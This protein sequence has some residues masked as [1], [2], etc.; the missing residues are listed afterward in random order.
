M[1]ALLLKEIRSFLSSLIGYIVISVFLLLIGLFTWVFSTPFNI[2]ES[3]FAD[4]DPLFSLAPLVFLFL[5][6]AITMRTFAEEKRTGTIEL[7]LTRP[8]TD[9]QIVLSKYLAGLLLVLFSL[10]PTLVYYF[11]ISRLGDPPGNVDT[12]GMWGS[13]L[14]LLL[15]GAGFVAIGMF[16]SALT[17][18]QIVAFII[19]V[20]LC[21]FFYLG[22]DFLGSYSL[23]G[24]YD[25][26]VKNL[27]IF[28]HYT[29]LSRGVVDSRDVIYFLSLIVFF[30]LLTRVVLE[31]RKRIHAALF[32][33]S[34]LIMVAVNII[35][36]FRFVRFDLTE[37]KRHSLSASTIHFLEDK[38]EDV[39][40]FK[41]YLTGNLPAELKRVEREIR[42][43]LEEMVAYAGDRIQYEFFDPY[44][45]E[46]EKARMTLMDELDYEKK[47]KYSQ[48]ESMDKGKLSVNFLF[49]GATL[50]FREKEI[51]FNFFVKP[52]IAREENV[53][54]LADA[55]INNIEYQLMDAMRKAIR[56]QKPRIAILEGHGEADADRLGIVTNALREFYNVERVAIDNQIHA[57]LEFD[58]VLIVKPQTAFSEKDKFVIDQF[59][60]K[61]GKAAWFIDPLEVREDT[62][63]KR[64]QT[65]G[66]SRNLNLDDQLF[67]YGIA[68]NKNLIVDK[69][70]APIAIPGYANQFHEWYFFPLITPER[71][72]PITRSIDPIKTQYASSLRMVGEDAGMKKTV[73]LKSSPTSFFYNAPVR[74][75][76]GVI[77]MG[78]N[79]WQNLK[80]EQP[81]AILLEGEFN[82]VF[83]NRLAPEFTS[84]PDY[85]Y[86]ERSRANR[87]L[88]VG[89]GDLILNEVDS[90]EM[91]GRM[92]K[93]YLKLSHDKYRITNP[94]GSPRFI[95]G[96]R[97]FL[98][99]A[100]DYLLGDNELIE[101]RQRTITIRRLDQE[102][103][104]AE[105]GMWQFVN[106]ALPVLL[107]ICF[108]F[109]QHLVRKR[110]YTL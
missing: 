61:G 43:K 57:L 27:G 102:K 17:H 106:V 97:E 108:G 7:L 9:M 14:G 1:L 86:V 74:I 6:P 76:Y 65:F 101:I 94:D 39:A 87:M 81:I 70:A 48:I 12:G 92:E 16:S 95:Y 54:R 44:S 109:I 69:I 93:R 41:I 13:Y 62:L 68:L 38:L 4:L 55:A 15:L 104:M 10:L 45:I 50:S 24:G 31:S 22:F 66:L 107:L 71:S 34:V 63:F 83:K 8:L 51:S 40:Y 28:S 75:N 52:Y 59:I 82:S 19:S 23:F 73:L 96:N 79:L 18:N 5:V 88:V 110:R 11:S 72:H 3:G 36:S 85:V 58:A 67:T 91:Q 33:V 21:F 49:P 46:D 84:S 98:L 77:D 30:L 105:R 64:G 60:M 2:A 47:I 42:E 90:V 35:G 32:L 26:F 56:V 89:D 80:P 100:M 53:Q 78:E 20:F 29:S 99:N 37:E 103:L 25:G